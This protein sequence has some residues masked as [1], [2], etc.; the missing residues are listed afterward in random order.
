MKITGK[1][2]FAT[3]ALALALAVPAQVKIEEHRAKGYLQIQI[4]DPQPG[5]F[6]FLAVGSARLNARLPFGA[7]LLVRPDL[8]PTLRSSD[9]DVLSVGPSGQLRANGAGRVE[10]IASVEGVTRTWD[11]EVDESPVGRVRVSVESAR[12]RTGDAV[13]AG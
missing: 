9:P 10:V 4:S 5:S 11:V 6:L 3:A 12:I 13:R 1:T 8:V 7:Q 2:M